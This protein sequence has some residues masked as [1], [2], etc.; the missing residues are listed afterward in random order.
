MVS[1]MSEHV[2]T[3][4]ASHLLIKHTRSRH[5]VS[6][7]SGMA[8]TVSRDDAVKE[9]EK[10]LEVVNA[11]NFPEHAGKRSDCGSFIRNGDLGFFTRGQMQKA[12]EDA[13][14]AMKIG[15]ISG[16]VETDSGI[17]IIHRTG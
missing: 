14:F 5:P 13:V 11:D 4:R 15:E 9:A 2:E 8:V 10:L 3:V 16:V 1:I 12:F 6:K 7:R 17:H